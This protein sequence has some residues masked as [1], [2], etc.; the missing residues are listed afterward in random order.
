[1]T[2][3]VNMYIITKNYYNMNQKDNINSLRTG[4]PVIDFISGKTD[5]LAAKRLTKRICRLQSLW[6]LAKMANAVKTEVSDCFK[7]SAP[8]M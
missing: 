6:I 3:G 7:E 8:D 2:G 5:T 4:E 1:M